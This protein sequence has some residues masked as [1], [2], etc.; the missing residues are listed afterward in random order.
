MPVHLWQCTQEDLV[1]SRYIATVILSLVSGVPELPG[2][3][4]YDL[5]PW[6]ELLTPDAENISCD[7]L[8]CDLDTVSHPASL[9]HT[10]V[11]LFRERLMHFELPVHCEGVHGGPKSCVLV[12]LFKHFAADAGSEVYV[13][14]RAIVALLGEKQGGTDAQR[15]VPPTSCS[16]TTSMLA[17]V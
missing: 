11:D 17:S 1:K 16:D 15:S 10:Y 5:L 3:P 2:Q 4:T 9:D 13:A 14:L 8:N 6:S 7:L 12:P